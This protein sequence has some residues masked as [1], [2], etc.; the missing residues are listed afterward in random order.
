MRGVFALTF[1]FFADIIIQ[2]VKNLLA[3]VF[4]FAVFQTKKS[5]NVSFLLKPVRV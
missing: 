1:A 3:R 5:K 2:E 4:N